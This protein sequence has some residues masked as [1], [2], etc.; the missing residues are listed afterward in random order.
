MTKSQIIAFITGSI[1]IILFSWFVSLREGRY[2]GIP[3][4]FAF[5][6]L[7]ALGLLNSMVWFKDPFSFP[8]IISWCLLILSIYYAA[9][10]FR[11]ILRHGKPGLNFEN[12]TRLVTTGL[13]HY[14]RHPMYGSLLFLGW[15]MFLKSCNIYTGILIIIIA[16]SLFI[17]CKIEEKE[18]I[19][20]FGQEYKDYIY[21]T[22]MWIPRVV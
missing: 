17:T 4:F 19:K 12:T 10:A 21:K 2:H 11:L 1:L 20:K 3:R 15:G 8:Q 5:E 22:K 9:D 7:L 13:Y 14:I 16:I 18:M 6:G